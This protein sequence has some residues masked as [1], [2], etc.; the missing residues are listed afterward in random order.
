[1]GE[2]K[3]RRSWYRKKRWWAAAAL[4]LVTA[5]PLSILPV[6][7]SVGRGWVSTADADPFYVPLF[8]VIEHTIEETP[9]EAA[10]A[11]C[12]DAAVDLGRKHAGLPQRQRAGEPPTAVH[13]SGGPRQ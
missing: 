2:P 6:A 13:P 12:L 8:A 1:M 10:F 7:Y 5:Y 3:A 4:W 9:P 11:R